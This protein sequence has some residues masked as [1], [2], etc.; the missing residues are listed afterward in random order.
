M[1]NKA[2]I[3][4]EISFGPFQVSTK[5]SYLLLSLSKFLLNFFFQQIKQIKFHNIQ[6]LVQIINSR[7]IFYSLT[8]KEFSQSSFSK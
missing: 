2:I 4:S 1:E 3:P 5:C 6:D 7:S 8:F